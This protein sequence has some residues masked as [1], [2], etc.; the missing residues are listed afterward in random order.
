MDGCQDSGTVQAAALGLWGC[1]D[2]AL[3]CGDSV[4]PSRELWIGEAL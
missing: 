3:G 1:K 2:G 4:R